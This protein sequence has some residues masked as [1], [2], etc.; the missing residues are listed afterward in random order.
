MIARLNEY[1]FDLIVVLEN[2][3]LVITFMNN[4]N[5]VIRIQFSL[6]LKVYQLLQMKMINI[7]FRVLVFIINAVK[8]RD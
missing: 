6:C 2:V 7:G 5:V 4:Y 1:L 3:F 8:H